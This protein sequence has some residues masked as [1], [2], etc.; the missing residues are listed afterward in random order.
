M[1][2]QEIG[3]LPQVSYPGG[4][5]SMVVRMGQQGVEVEWQVPW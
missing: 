1:Q 5:A 4:W 3:D 2:V